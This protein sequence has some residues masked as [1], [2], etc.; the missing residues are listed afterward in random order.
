M[1]AYPLNSGCKGVPLREI[2]E[3]GTSGM[4]LSPGTCFAVDDKA[5]DAD[6]SVHASQ[7]SEQVGTQTRRRSDSSAHASQGGEQAGTQTRRRSDSPAHA[8]QGSEQVG[9][10]A[11]QGR[12]QVGTQTPR[13]S[14]NIIMRG[15]SLH[16]IIQLK[17]RDHHRIRL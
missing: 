15:F 4:A 11:R 17:L 13:R 2:D 1:N 9:A 7:G 3:S 5:K 8:S 12:E 16:V 6:L 14:A 10:Q